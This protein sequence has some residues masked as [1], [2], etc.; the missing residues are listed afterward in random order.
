MPGSGI[1]Y[2]LTVRDAVQ[3]AEWLALHGVHAVAYTGDSG[4]DRPEL[5]QALLDNRVKALVATTALGMGFDKPDLG[6][7]IH[8]QTPGSVVAYYQQVG[9]AGR[10]L[11]AAYGILLSGTEEN[12]INEYFIKTAFPTRDEVQQILR[13]LER[14]PQGLS[15]PGLMASVNVAKGRIEKTIDLL[16]LE[17]PAP[18]VK[19]GTRWQLTATNLSE[20]FWQRAQRLTDLRH[21]EQGQMQEYVDLPA[22][23]MAFLIRALDGEP[24]DCRS[25]DLPDLPATVDQL[26]VREAVAFLRRT[27]LPI[28]PRRQ[29]P[30]DTMPQ[31]GLKGNIPR[32]L[33]AEPGKTLCTWGDAGWGDLVRQGKCQGHHVAEDLVV[34]CASMV[35]EWNPQPAP[36]WVTCIPSLRDPVFVQDV[37][38]RLAQQLGLPFRP[39]ICR[40]IDRPPQATMQNSMQQAHNL[41]GSFELTEALPAGPVLLVDDTVDSRWTMTVAAWLLRS[42]G[43]G[44]VYPMALASI[45]PGG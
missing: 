10:A 45:G 2:T 6:F 44:E 3:V 42:H 4:S 32:E 19:Q 16:S 43:S 34:A 29:W 8:Y 27:S 41:D 31:Y 17:S 11:D 18:I 13:V 36:T 20:E 26:L 22:G 28:D 25:P 12:D 37:A 39:V 24:G 23:H 40:S 35:Q 5:E 38:E 15:L 21:V 14:S 9:R 30:L 33:Q 1:V 7:V